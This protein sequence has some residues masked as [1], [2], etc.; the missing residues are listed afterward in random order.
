MLYNVFLSDDDLN[1]YFNQE[2]VLSKS[3]EFKSLVFLSKEQ[4]DMFSEL[5]VQRLVKDN[6]INN[7]SLFINTLI[8]STGNDDSLCKIEFKD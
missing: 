2:P 7:A 5:M 8:S 3:T 4:K 6:G 1:K